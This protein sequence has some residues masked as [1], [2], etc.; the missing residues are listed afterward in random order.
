MKNKLSLMIGSFSLILATGFIGCSKGKKL[1]RV[2]EGNPWKV[3]AESLQEGMIL[4][5]DKHG[6]LPMDYY[7]E[8]IAAL[9]SHDE[10]KVKTLTTEAGFKYLQ[11]NTHI[12]K[13]YEKYDSFDIILDQCQFWKNTPKGIFSVSSQHIPLDNNDPKFMDDQKFKKVKDEWKLV[14]FPKYD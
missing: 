6:K 1:P 8:F 4:T 7:K 9:K 12:I 11:K 10:S 5:K 14:F 2:S 3:K 13:N